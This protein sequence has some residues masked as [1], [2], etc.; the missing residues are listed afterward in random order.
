MWFDDEVIDGRKLFRRRGN[1]GRNTI[2]KVNTR[3]ADKKSSQKMGGG[4]FLAAVVV[5]LTLSVWLGCKFAGQVLFS[6]NDRFKIEHLNIQEG[7]VITS[8]LIREYTQIEKGMNLFS[9]DIAKVR[10]DFIKQSPNVKSMEIRRQLPDTLHIRVVE[11][12]PVARIGKKSPFVADSEGFVF[13]VR[14]GYRDLPVVTGYRDPNLRP[15]GRLCGIALAALE[16]LEACYDP[17]VGLRIDEVEVNNPESLVLYVPDA[18]KVK[19]VELS[20]PEMG[21]RTVESRKKLME[22]LAWIV[23]ALQSEEGR[24]ALRLNATIDGRFF[25]S[26]GG[27]TG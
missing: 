3:L 15:G 4:V 18:G 11:R 23:K 10:K 8:D 24:K 27:A 22:R 13:N 5:G 16:V 25:A 12:V 9:F 20:W 14:T 19:E 26:G 17:K 6:T 21:T 7:T 1:G 2:L